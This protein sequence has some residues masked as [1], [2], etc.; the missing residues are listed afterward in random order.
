MENINIQNIEAIPP[1]EGPH[2]IPGI[3]FRPARTALG[4][5]SWGMNII[6]LDPDCTGYP[7]HDHASEGHEEVYVILRGAVV[8]HAGGEERTL[9][10]GDMVRV[11]PELTRKFVTKDQA[12][13]A[14]R[15]R[16]YPRR[17]LQARDGRIEKV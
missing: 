4:V 3:R 6:E 11:S 9:G 17:G 12:R 16:W 2:E 1:Y 7:E 15:A 14:P 8:L 10:Q 13:H 5:T